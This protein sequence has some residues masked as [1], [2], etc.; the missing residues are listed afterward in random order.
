MTDMRLVPKTIAA[1]A[2]SAAL[3]GSSTLAAAAPAPQAQPAQAATPDAWMMLSTLS[4]A[5]SVG[6][7][8]ANAAV[9]PTDVPPPPPPPVA[10]GAMGDGVGELIPFVL[11]FGL[12]A[13]ALSISGSPGGSAV[14]TP[15]SAG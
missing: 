9:Q 1:I 10:A 15:N 8:G 3:L 7:A 2:A 12:I 11:W 6:L 13:I 4:A 14:I 5:Q